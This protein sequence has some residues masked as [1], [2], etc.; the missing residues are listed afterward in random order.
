MKP[1]CF[2]FAVKPRREALLRERCA[3]VLPVRRFRV[4]NVHAVLF[5][6]QQQLVDVP[7]RFPLKPSSRTQSV[8]HLAGWQPVSARSPS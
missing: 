4:G 1:S 8:D 6:W 3:V 5:R 2:A 7:Q